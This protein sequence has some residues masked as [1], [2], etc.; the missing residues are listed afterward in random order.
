MHPT[1]G[2]FLDRNVNC[3]QD[4]VK[5]P[6]LAKSESGYR[7]EDDDNGDGDDD[8]DKNEDMLLLQSRPLPYVRR[9]E[10]YV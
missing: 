1:A 6:R 10:V 7:N 9:F 8:G 5:D 2:D 4:R 3:L